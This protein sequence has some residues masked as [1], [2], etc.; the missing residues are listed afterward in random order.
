MYLQPTSPFRA[1]DD[2]DGC[3]ER[4]VASSDDSCVSV[5]ESP[6]KP[7]W[8]FFI[9]PDSHLAPVLGKPPRLRRQ[10][11][12][13][14]YELNGAVYAARIP[15]YERAGTFLTDRTLPWIMPADRGL[16]LDELSDFDR[17]EGILR[18]GT[19]LAG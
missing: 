8:L 1:A 10:E 19:G 18:L 7:E 4:L 13:V 5:T 16:D 9:G 15:A 6:A 2:I 17:A 3:L 14:A 11:L 12:Q